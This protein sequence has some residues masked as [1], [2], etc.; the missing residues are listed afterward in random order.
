MRAD[1]GLCSSCGYKERK[2]TAGLF[3]DSYRYRPK[4]TRP[5]GARYIVPQLEDYHIKW[6]IGS[7][8]THR[9]RRFEEV[10]ARF[11]KS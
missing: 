1:M 11:R 9:Q 4:T 5:K 8:V 6:T 2:K 7:I 10:E 3:Y